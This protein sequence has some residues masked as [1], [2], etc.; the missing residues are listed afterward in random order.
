MQP[1]LVFVADEAATL[2]LAARVADLLPSGMRLG[3]SGSLGAGKT[4]FARAVAR[5]LGVREAV[6]SPTFVLVREYA[7]ADEHPG[8]GPSMLL[9]L[10]LYRLSPAEVPELLAGCEDAI[11]AGAV[12]L[13]E[14]PERA[15]GDEPIDDL[16]LR[17][18]LEPPPGAATVEIGAGASAPTD[19]RW[20]ELRAR[21]EPARRLIGEL[22]AT[23][24]PRHV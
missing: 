14:W 7:L 19:P 3:L 18:H 11:A 10:D 12:A 9:H 13:I 17:L 6:T 2:A 5:R 23:E 1:L 8:P 21:S 20:I 16:R 15:G 24:A 22:A 4:T